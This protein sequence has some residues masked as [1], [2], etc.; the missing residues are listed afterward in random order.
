MEWFIL[1]GPLN[2]D[3]RVRFWPVFLSR[4]VWHKG[5]ECHILVFFVALMELLVEMQLNV[6]NFQDYFLWIFTPMFLL[7]VIEFWTTIPI[8]RLQRSFEFLGAL[9]LSTQQWSVPGVALGAKWGEVG[10][11]MDKVA[12]HKIPRLRWFFF[13]KVLPGAGLHYAT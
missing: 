12:L 5:T 13:S 4:I 3:N 8:F 9:Y 7:D 10:R 6:L 1:F 2:N 11:R